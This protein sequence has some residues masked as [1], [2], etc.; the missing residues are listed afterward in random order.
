MESVFE[1]DVFISFTRED[2]KQVEKLYTRLIDFGI[3][4]FWSK[5]K[6]DPN[7]GT[8]F[9][10][11]IASALERSQHFVLYWTTKAATS[12]WVEKEWTT[13][14]NNYHIKDENNRR[15]Y[16]HCV[17]PF[18][19]LEIPLLIKEILRP[20]NQVH[21]ISSLVRL[22]YS[23]SIMKLKETSL[24]QKEY[25][26]VVEGQLEI[27]KRKA[28]EARDFY[29]HNRF[30]RPFTENKHIHIFTCARDIPH[31]NNNRRGLGGRTSIDMWDYRSAFDITHFFA[32]MYPGT[33]VTIEDPVIKLGDDDLKEAKLVGGHIAQMMGMLEDKDCIIIGSPDVSDF[34]EI[35]LAQIHKISPYSTGREKRK[36]FVIIKERKF[37]SSAFYWEKQQDEEEGVAQIIKPN[38]Y[39]FYANSLAS[40]ERGSGKMYGILVVA[41]NPFSKNKERRNKI[42]ILSGFSGVATNSVSKILTNEE[43]L[44]EFFKL[45]HAYENIEK[46]IEALIGVKYNIDQN[47]LQRDTR[48]IE[49]LAKDITFEKLIEI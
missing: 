20:R 39:K 40:D 15:M 28:T 25:L 33:K 2:G 24:Q 4:V 22:V 37:T 41:N 49:N 47:Y 9:T 48:R 43:C 12:P 10:K 14:F 16:I 30:W 27:E 46:P 17:E 6:L 45:D 38:D 5:E 21:L 23:N 3:R 13:F 19:N 35:V 34:A 36:G 8:G 29:R 18:E 42:L 31:D 44:G 1:Y 26:K 11:P 7:T 32:L